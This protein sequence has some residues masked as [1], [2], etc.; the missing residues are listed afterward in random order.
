[1][2][3]HLGL[4]AQPFKCPHSAALRRLREALA[5]LAAAVLAVPMT[6]QAA[7]ILQDNATTTA[8][9]EFYE[10]IGQSFTAEDASVSFAFYYETMNVGEL[11]DPLELRLLS[12]DGLGGSVLGSFTFTLPSESFNGFFDVDLSSIAL[13]VGLTYTATVNVPGT[14][15]LWGVQLQDGGNPYAG[16]R[17]YV[18]RTFTGN[19]LGDASDDARFRVTPTAVPEPAT[20]ALLGFGLAGLGFSRRRKQ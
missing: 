14:S 5:L 18:G 4:L 19:T 9:V 11:N 12:G 3:R 6:A 15:D 16:G 10:P 2:A 20:L 8:L 7:L 1:M 13:T 17:L